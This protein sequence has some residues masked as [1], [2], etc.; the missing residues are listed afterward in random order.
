MFI[1]SGA[2]GGL[3]DI[4]KKRLQAQGLGFTATVSSR[5]ADHKFLSHLRSEDLIEFGFESEFVGRLPVWAVLDPLT[6]ADLYEILRNPNNPI[7]TSK[8]KDFKSYNIDLK[9]DDEALHAFAAQAGAEKTGARGLVS[10]IER[11]LITFEARLPSTDIKRLSVTARTVDNPEAD[12]E[13][14]LA[15]PD[16]PDR[17]EAFER[18]SA[19]ERADIMAVI[20][21]SSDLLEY[22]Y[23]LPLTPARAAL[24]ADF[25]SDQFLDLGSAATQLDRIYEEVEAC[26]LEFFEKHG[27]T[28]EFTEGAA[29]EMVRRVMLEG[30]RPE[31]VCEMFTRDFEYGLNMIKDKTGQSRFT[32]SRE[33]VLNPEEYL[34]DLITELF[35]LD[36]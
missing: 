4:I 15:E 2:F 30:I 3:A 28:I 31:N 14:L 35:E 22:R 19:E 11:S 26:A 33:G 5:E 17:V 1:V 9:I 25:I 21:Q 13:R 10:A 32:I 12:L 20:M 8:K 7:I 36:G 6:E 16:A 18:L 27:L 23:S 34:N 24:L 29:D